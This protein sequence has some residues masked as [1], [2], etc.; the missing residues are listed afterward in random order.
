MLTAHY[1]HLGL[2]MFV[3]MAESR[4]QLQRLKLCCI[5][6]FQSLLRSN[7]CTSPCSFLSLFNRQHF[8]LLYLTYFRL[9][10]ITYWSLLFNLQFKHYISEVAINHVWWSIIFFLLFTVSIT[11]SFHILVSMLSSVCGDFFI[12][13]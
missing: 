7:Q 5:Y 8:L 6:N 4:K 13:Y 3:W 1:S 9:N 10:I 2:Q 11:K 12:T